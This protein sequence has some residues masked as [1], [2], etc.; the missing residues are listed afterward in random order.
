MYRSFRILNGNLCFQNLINTKRCNICSREHNRHCSDHQE[1]HN[2]LHCILDKCHNITNLH[3]SVVYCMGTTV[4]NKYRYS[5]HDQHHNGHHKSHTSV[6]KQV[7]FCQIQVCLLEALFFMF[8]T[9]ECT[10][11]R[12]T[13]KDLTGYQIQSVDQGLQDSEFGHCHLEQ[14]KDHNQDQCNCHPKDPCH[15]RI[16]IQYLDHATNT[17]DRRVQNNTEHHC[18]NLLYLLHI[19]GASC[20]QGCCGEFVIFSAGEAHNL[21]VNAVSQVMAKS[22]CHSGRNKCDADRCQ[23]DHQCHGKH[24]DT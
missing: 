16:C 20:D 13:C 21:T 15:R 11:N 19:I 7:C 24:S 4:N 23:H 12:N 5:V 14:H 17:K 2:D 22:A 3:G 1:G 18:H 8:L 10:D 6:D 9:A